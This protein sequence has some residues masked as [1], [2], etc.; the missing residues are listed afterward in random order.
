MG[1]KWVMKY[2]Y[3]LKAYPSSLLNNCKLPIK[4]TI[5]NV[6]RKIPVKLMISFLP[7]EELK[8]GF[9]LLIILDILF[10]SQ[11]YLFVNRN[12]TIGNKNRQFR[13]FLIKKKPCRRNSMQGA[14]IR[15]FAFR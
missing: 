4:W 14:V 12:L 15:C 6:H 3:L 10:D 7:S 5:R 1:V 2:A 11:I 8:T 13:T 9:E